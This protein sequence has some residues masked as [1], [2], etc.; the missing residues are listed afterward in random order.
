MPK[1][2]LAALAVALLAACST[3]DGPVLR[4]VVFKPTAPAAS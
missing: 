2:I 3:N 4:E 1:A